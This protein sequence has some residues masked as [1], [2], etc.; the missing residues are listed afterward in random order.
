MGFLGKI[1]SFISN[2]IADIVGGW[3]GRKTIAAQ[4]AAEI[5][6]AEVAFKI[7]R[8]EIKERALERKLDQDFDYDM[9]V[10]NNRQNSMADELIILVF[11]AV[12]LLHFVPSTQSYMQ[13][14]WAAMG[15]TDGPPW[16]FEFGMV[17]ILV[18]TLGLMRVLRLFAGRFG[19]P[20]KEGFR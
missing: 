9:Q 18:S 20:N 2:P 5:K 16:W 10:L 19:K 1:L 15:Y 12:F 17:G 13:L 7:K 4:S 8:F 14:G 3:Q 11:F 6:A